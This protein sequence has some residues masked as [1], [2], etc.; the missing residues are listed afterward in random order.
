MSEL[1]DAGKWRTV[2]QAKSVALSNYLEDMLM[3][4][5]LKLIVLVLS[6]LQLLDFEVLRASLDF[7]CDFLLNSSSSGRRRLVP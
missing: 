5:R 4:D 1:I 6:Y 2:L 7:R 3:A